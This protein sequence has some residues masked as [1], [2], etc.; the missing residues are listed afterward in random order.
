[1]FRDHYCKNKNFYDRL[2]KK[3]VS[4]NGLKKKLNTSQELQI[5]SAMTADGTTTP[6]NERLLYIEKAP[7]V[8]ETVLPKCKIG[9]FT[10]EKKARFNKIFV[11]ERKR[12]TA[13]KRSDVEWNTVGKIDCYFNEDDT[14]KK[15]KIKSRTIDDMLNA[16]TPRI[17]AERKFAKRPTRVESGLMKLGKKLGA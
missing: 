1:M 16:P 15:K 2:I 6:Y 10:E 3:I 12:D 8:I 11:I 7:S 5:A 9:I 13:R 17:V 4:E 14:K